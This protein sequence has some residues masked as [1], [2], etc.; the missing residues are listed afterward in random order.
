MARDGK[1]DI[2]ENDI[3]EQLL[4]ILL[5]DHTTGR[6]I[7]WACDD[8]EAL[9][10]GYAFGDTIELAAIT[11]D[12]SNVIMPRVMKDK[13]L[14]KKRAKE[15]DAASTAPSRRTAAMTGRLATSHCALQR[16]RHGRTTSARTASR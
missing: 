4:G 13:S 10:K 12:N 7:F 6:N 5:R 15:R 11:G 8:Y 1:V 3:P 9:G 2:F 16:A 14:K